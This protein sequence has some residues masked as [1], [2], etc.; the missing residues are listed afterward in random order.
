MIPL[1]SLDIEFS[2]MTESVFA[3]RFGA[4][5]FLAIGPGFFQPEHRIFHPFE[6]A[7]KMW[8]QLIVVM[9]IAC[10][11]Y[12]LA[13]NKPIFIADLQKIAGLGFLTLLV[14]D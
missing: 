12:S 2:S 8:L 4:K 1:V 5:P 13:D 7:G 6:A 9:V 11:D 10:N 3:S 14:N